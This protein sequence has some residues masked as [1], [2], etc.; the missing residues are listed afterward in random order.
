MRHRF[1]TAFAVAVAGVIATAALTGAGSAGTSSPTVTRGTDARLCPFPIEIAV[2]GTTSDAVAPTTAFGL[3]FVGPSTVSIRNTRSGRTAVI[4][5]PGTFG[6]RRTTG[7]VSFAGRRVWFRP[8]LVPFLVTAGRG[9]ISGP[10]F[11]LSPGSTTA[12]AVDPCALV[13]DTNPSTQ[14]RVTPAPWTLPRYALSQMAAAGLTPLVGNLVE[15]DHVH[16]DITVN[17]K[18]VAV[19]GGL[20]LAEPTDDGP[21]PDTKTAPVADCVAG[22]F[23]AAAVA[24]SPLH[25]HSGSGV[26]HVESDRARAFTLGQVFAEWGVRLDHGCIG[27]YCT[28]GRRELRVY[29]NGRRVSGDPALIKLVDHAEIAIVYGGVGAFSKIPSTFRGGTW[30]GPGCGQQGEASCLTGAR[31]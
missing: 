6:E 4:N 10:S 3:L 17:G 22:H 27:G 16:L 8:N 23:F 5:A 18:K 28:D 29:L 21:C 7:T 11:V 25:T 24:N 14:P 12:R 2:R 19:P 31:S 9:A 13:A 30:P 15:H 20:G 1:F 26:I